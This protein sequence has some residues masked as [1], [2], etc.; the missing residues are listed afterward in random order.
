M[1]FFQLAH[2]RYMLARGGRG[3]DRLTT[4]LPM[5]PSDLEN[6]RSLVVAAHGGDSGAFVTLL[7]QYSWHI[8]RLSVS[9]TGNHHVPR[10]SSRN[11]R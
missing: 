3:S 1:T 5:M 6:E 10:T 4:L 9:I 2:L 7:N 11:L 8:Y